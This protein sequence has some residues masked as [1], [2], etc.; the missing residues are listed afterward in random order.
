MRHDR[1]ASP[2]GVIVEPRGDALSF[3]GSVGLA[4]GVSDVQCGPWL[5][6]A[7]QTRDSVIMCVLPFFHIYGMNML[8]NTTLF[9]RTHMVTMPSSISNL[10]ELHQKRQ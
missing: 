8:L 3:F 5:L 4:P 10:L 7:V 2:I 6:E 1:G 9:N